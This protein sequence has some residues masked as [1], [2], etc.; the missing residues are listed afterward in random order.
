[1]LW[2]AR[3]GNQLRSPLLQT[4]GFL[5]HRSCRR[6]DGTMGGDERFDVIRINA[7]CGADTDRWQ[8]T[9]VDQSV[10]E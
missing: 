2:Y 9:A 1:M 6:T 7:D 4:A 10:N 5:V 3:K 8:L